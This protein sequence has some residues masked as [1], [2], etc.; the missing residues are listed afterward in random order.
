MSV[1]ALF[2]MHLALEETI[3]V[4]Q[5]FVAPSGMRSLLEDPPLPDVMCLS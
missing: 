5:G 2:F 1:I 3:F 4:V